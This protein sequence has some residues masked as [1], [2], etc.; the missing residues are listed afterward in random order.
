MN[1]LGPNRRSE[2]VVHAQPKN[3]RLEAVAGA[4]QRVALVRQVDVEILGLGRPIRREADLEAGAGRPA[5]MSVALGKAVDLDLA[6]AEGETN[7]A[8][9]QHVVEGDAGARA[10]RAEPR[11]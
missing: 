4:G 10:S 5:D 3:G 8:V 9:E 1:R 6:A 7:G 2:P 11:I